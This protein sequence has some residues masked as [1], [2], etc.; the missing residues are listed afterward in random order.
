MQRAAKLKA[1]RLVLVKP[2]NRFPSASFVACACVVS[3]LARA[4]VFFGACHSAK[5]I[6]HR[7]RG[8]HHGN[9]SERNP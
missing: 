3:M 1:F 7:P 5:L 9:L 2:T 6:T 4:S 8:G